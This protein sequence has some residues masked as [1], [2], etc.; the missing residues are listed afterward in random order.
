MIKI[1]FNLLNYIVLSENN[2]QIEGL[3]YYNNKASILNFLNNKKI[4]IIKEIPFLSAIAVCFKSKEVF[5]LSKQNF[6]TYISSLATAKTLINVSKRIIGVNDIK[7]KGEGQTVAIIDTGISPHI[8]FTLKNNRIIKFCDF[9]NNYN[10][11]YDD[12]GHGTYVSGILAGSG[13]LSNG[14]YEGIVPKANIISLKALSDKGEAN[15]VTILEAMQWVYDNHKAYKIGTVCMSF[16]SEPLGNYDPIMKGAEKLWNEG[17]IV[18]CAAGNSGPKYQTIKSP[19][20]SKKI[21][22][23][24]GLDDCRDEMGN[25]NYKDFKVAEF[26]SRGPANNRIKPDIIAPCVNITSCSYNGNYTKMSGTSVATP[27]VAGL[28]IILKQM[29]PNITPEQ[30]KTYLLK[31]AIPI[32]ENRFSQ[33]YG[34]AYLG[35]N[36]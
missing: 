6:V 19:G 13:L 14:L 28:A 27:M 33:G 36:K 31:N 22:T 5:E 21:I 25:F 17:I 32:K 7:Y 26:S 18:V 10:Y 3:I 9:V 30:V 35:D 24:G 11:P 29:Y 4:K 34:V 15:A 23:V 20:I 2:C 16:G 1:D 12:N 8:D